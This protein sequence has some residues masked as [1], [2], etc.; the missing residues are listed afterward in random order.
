MELRLV[1]QEYASAVLRH[2]WSI[3]AGSLLGLV[4]V[5]ERAYGVWL[6]PPPWLSWT[7]AVL[8]LIVAQ[9]L[10]YRDLRRAKD[11]DHAHLQREVERLK[12]RPYDAEH[13]KLAEAKVEALSAS[14]R[15]LLRF[16]LH[17]GRTE[18]GQ[19]RLSCQDHHS[20]FEEAL[21]RAR[22]SGLIMEVYEPGVGRA[23][24]DLCWQVNPQFEVVL[25][26]ILALVQQTGSPHFVV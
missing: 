22:G 2:W 8:G 11:E 12:V 16:L 13:R 6:L 15:D 14:G 24:V 26:D 3:V 4:D 23:G 18:N 5:I 25:K 21:S 9:F 17:R 19:L 7:T 1:L 20:V 10:A